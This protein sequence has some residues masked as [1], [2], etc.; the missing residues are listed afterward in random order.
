MQLVDEGSV[1]LDAP[2]RQYLPR[3]R[4]ADSEATETTVTIGQLAFLRVVPDTRYAVALLT[5]G[6]T[7][8]ASYRDL[9][10]RL[11]RERAGIVLPD[12]PQAVEGVEFDR[13]RPAG[14]YE[15]TSV[16]TRIDAHGEDG[17]RR[18]QRGDEG[19]P[20]RVAEEVNA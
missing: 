19:A 12:P 2:V 16:R 9:F 14:T 6:P 11:L 5:N 18:D 13:L 17:G 10:G 1:E 8:G 15:R 7:G 20:R 4:L 3:L